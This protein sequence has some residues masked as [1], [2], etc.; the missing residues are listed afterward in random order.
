MIQRR[1]TRMSR[2]ME[3]LLYEKRLNRLRLFSLKN[4][5]LKNNILKVYKAVIVQRR[6]I[7][8]DYV[9]VFIIQE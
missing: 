2:N 7:R 4:R 5:W 8:N 1:A 9:L 6:Q 3:Q